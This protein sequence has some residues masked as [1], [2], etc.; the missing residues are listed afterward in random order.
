MKKLIILM[1]L[2]LGACTT[3]PQVESMARPATVIEISNKQAVLDKI[4]E[5][6]DRNGLQI[7]N[8]EA[9]SVT[10]SRQSSMATQVLLGTKY[11]TALRTRTQFN[12]FPIS[13]G[14]IK[15]APR[16]WAEN[17]NAFGQ[18]NTTEMDTAVVR[19][20]T[21]TILDQARTELEKK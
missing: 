5:L 11:G 6:C 13:K 14:K 10:C 21:Q 9:S 8:T 3:F 12:V 17:Q 1:P 4:V 19:Q 16:S 7:D 18:I 15:V 20:Y 2:A